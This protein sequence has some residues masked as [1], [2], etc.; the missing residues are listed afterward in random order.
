M[1]DVNIECSCGV[2]KIYIPDAYRYFS[3]YEFVCTGC[4]KAYSGFVEKEKWK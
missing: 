3:D 2:M 1:E 4:G